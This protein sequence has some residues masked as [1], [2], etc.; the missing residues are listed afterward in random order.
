MKNFNT[1]GVHWKI[2]FLGGGEF[3][4][5]QYTGGNFLKERG[6]EQLADLSLT[7]KR[8]VFFRGVIPQCTIC[9]IGASCYK[10]STI[11]KICL[12]APTIVVPWV[13]PW[14][15]II[16]LM[17]K[18]GRSCKT[19]HDAIQNE[20]RSWNFIKD[21]IVDR[22]IWRSDAKSAAKAFN[23]CFMEDVISDKSTSMLKPKTLI[24]ES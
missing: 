23:T 24:W 21:N 8:G 5:N 3:M 15:G 1:I 6:L 12:L 17:L 14:L 18:I 16:L 22:V 20:L 13:D 7:K 10:L 11:L 9:N 19:L 4:K 2:R